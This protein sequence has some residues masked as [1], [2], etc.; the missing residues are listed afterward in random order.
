M[1]QRLDADACARVTCSSAVK[2][3]FVLDIA[4]ALKS[5]E[6][7]D[8]ANFRTFFS[9]ETMLDFYSHLRYLN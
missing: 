9:S 3:V 6:Y 8:N 4:N 2:G 7:Y 5:E 1:A